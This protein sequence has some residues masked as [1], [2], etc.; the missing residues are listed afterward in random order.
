MQKSFF[1]VL[2]LIAL[3]FGIEAQAVPDKQVLP[4]KIGYTNVEYILSLLPERKKIESEYTSFE[5]QLSNQMQA[6][7]REFQ[8]K[9]GDFQQGNETMPEA[10][11]NK[12]QL[13]LQQLQNSLEQLRIESQE[14][15]AKKQTSLFKPLYEKIKS[16]IKEVA[17]EKG[18]THVFNASPGGMPVLIYASEEHDISKLVLKKLG[19]SPTKDKK[20]K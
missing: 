14:K 6:K 3:L 19:I 12:K 20:K 7:M 18:Y 2:T 17:K 9:A 4:L 15:L 10:V 13:E 11:R 1:L 16:K 5:K 8:K